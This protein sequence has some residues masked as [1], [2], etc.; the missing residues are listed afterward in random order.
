[1]LFVPRSHS[2]KRIES[3]LE[4]NC[5][6]ILDFFMVELEVLSSKLDHNLRSEN[7]H[8]RQILR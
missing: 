7:Y 3:R 5:S 1:M 4:I 6:H 8:V 2:K